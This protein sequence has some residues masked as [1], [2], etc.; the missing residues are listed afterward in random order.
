M[1]VDTGELLH[2]AADEHEPVI[3]VPTRWQCIV[4]LGV[5]WWCVQYTGGPALI[6]IR[7][8]HEGQR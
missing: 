8:Y 6:V 7:Y 5:L 1:K 2:R 3:D 4:G